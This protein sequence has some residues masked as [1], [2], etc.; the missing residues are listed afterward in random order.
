MKGRPMIFPEGSLCGC[1]VI[2][3]TILC[4]SKIAQIAELL[5]VYSP[6]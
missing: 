5:F 3:H 1:R 6:A 2:L 4:S